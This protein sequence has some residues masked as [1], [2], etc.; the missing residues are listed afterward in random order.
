MVDTLILP[1]CYASNTCRDAPMTIAPD[2]MDLNQVFD[3]VGYGIYCNQPSAT[4][5]VNT[6]IF[7]NRLCVML[8]CAF[9]HHP[10]VNCGNRLVGG[11]KSQHMLCLVKAKM[12]IETNLQKIE[13]CVV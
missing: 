11:S 12:S 1:G 8:Q 3:M 7:F 6:L 4:G 13:G 5:L 2:R 9:S 10:H